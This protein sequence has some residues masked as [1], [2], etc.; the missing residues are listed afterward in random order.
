MKSPRCF[1][2]NLPQTAAPPCLSTRRGQGALGPSDGPLTGRGGRGAVGARGASCRE[3]AACSRRTRAPRLQ[4]SPACPPCG[5]EGLAQTCPGAAGVD[6]PLQPAEASVAD[7]AAR[8]CQLGRKRSV[9]G[10]RPNPRATLLPAWWVCSTRLVRFTDQAGRPNMSGGHCRPTRRRSAGSGGRQ[11]HV[12]RLGNGRREALGAKQAS[13]TF[14][15]AFQVSV[16]HP[17]QGH[18]PTCNHVPTAPP[19]RPLRRPRAAGGSSLS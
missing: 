1:L 17:H 12:T 11:L 6:R 8:R 5:P 10:E 18:P 15:R 2:R 16:G 9:V 19:A 13:D 7:L 14:L 4:P 3:G